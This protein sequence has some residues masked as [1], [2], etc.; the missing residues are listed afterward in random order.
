MRLGSKKKMV[1]P[2]GFKEMGLSRN[3]KAKITASDKLP[4]ELVI[5][6]HTQI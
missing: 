2:K 1:K 6:K 4:R 3:S 5:L